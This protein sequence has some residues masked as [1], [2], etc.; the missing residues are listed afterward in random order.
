M[1]VLPRSEPVWGPALTNMLSSLGNAAG[2]IG[3]AHFMAKNKREMEKREKEQQAMNR[4]QQGQAF[5]SMFGLSPEQGMALATAPA[6]IQKSIVQQ[7]MDR[8]GFRQQQT[9]GMGGMPGGMMQQSPLDALQQL[10]APQ[11]NEIPPAALT[12]SS[13]AQSLRPEDPNAFLAQRILQGAATGQTPTALKPSA[14][15][16]AKEPTASEVIKGLDR[17]VDQAIR[18][19]DVEQGLDMAPTNISGMLA[20]GM[21][22][23]EAKKAV[24]DTADYYKEISKL[25]R[26]SVD[27]N[28]RLLRM[29]QLIDKNLKSGGGLLRGSARQTVL[30]AAEDWKSHAATGGLGGA[31]GGLIGTLLLPGIGTAGGAA[32]G[33]ALGAAAPTAYSAYERGTATPETQEFEKLSAEFVRGAKDVFGSRI[34]DADLNAFMKMVPTLANTDEGKLSVMRNLRLVNEGNIVKKKVADKIIR[35]NGGRR[36][37]NLEDMVETIS[38]PILDKL[39]SEFV[40]GGK[41]ILATQNAP[42]PTRPQPVTR[43]QRAFNPTEFDA[44]VY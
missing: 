10:Q 44:S 30:N 15:A 13:M 33:S 7:I 32:L 23:D 3:T 4:Q 1:I 39:S 14:P 2:N 28:R 34:T 6:D 11:M 40:Q 29:E 38:Q 9:Q 43:Q 25:G 16:V 42:S 26:A 20:S 12:M 18:S 41:S 5:S 27:D 31:I 22:K 24:S 19:Y 35:A 36:P 21:S 37:Y 17:E 8:G